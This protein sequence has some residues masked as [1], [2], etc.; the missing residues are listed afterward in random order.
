METRP[1]SLDHLSGGRHDLRE[2]VV[3]NALA[4]R[5]LMQALHDAGVQVHLHADDGSVYPTTVWTL[6]SQRETLV[7]AADGDPAVLERLLAASDV[8]AVAYLDNVKL[9]F[10]VADLVVVR[11]PQSAT[12]GASFPAVVWRF[13]RR[14]TFRAKAGVRAPAQVRLQLPGRADGLVA[15]RLL[16]VSQG[17]CALRMPPDLPPPA[18]GTSFAQVSLE[19]DGATRIATGLLVQHVTPLADGAA[20]TRLGC[21]FAGMPPQSARTL[22]RWIDDAQRRTRFITLG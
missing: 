22:Q 5:Q 8:V 3:D 17:G 6:D 18:P 15:L 1:T 9:Q 4:V 7:F 12:L 2:F 16:D 14:G 19:L 10:D 13:Q 21:A 20:G 11:G